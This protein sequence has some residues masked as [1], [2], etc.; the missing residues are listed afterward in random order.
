M[1]AVEGE[2]GDAAK[3]GDI[4]VLLADWLAEAPDLDLAGEL[5]E[6]L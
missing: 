2:A 5:R 6:L 3:R 1:I 4:L